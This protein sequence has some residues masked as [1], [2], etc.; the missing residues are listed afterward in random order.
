MG[1]EILRESRSNGPHWKGDWPPWE[2]GGALM[3]NA[4]TYTT[5]WRVP[6]MSIVSPWLHLGHII[7]HLYTDMDAY[8]FPRLS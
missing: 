5:A 2:T 6:A 3:D 1:S 7:P 4:R 8:Q